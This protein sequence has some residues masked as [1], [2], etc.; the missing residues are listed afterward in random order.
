MQPCKKCHK[1]YADF[2]EICVK[3]MIKDSQSAFDKLQEKIK[4]VL[5]YGESPAFLF[6]KTIKE[7]YHGKKRTPPKR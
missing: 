5:L 1:R 4:N 2:C 7:K 6:L 3:E